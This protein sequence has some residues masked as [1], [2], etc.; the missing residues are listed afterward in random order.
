[1]SCMEPLKFDENLPGTTVISDFKFY[2]VGA[3]YKAYA[4]I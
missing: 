2:I 3:T 1:M 4:F